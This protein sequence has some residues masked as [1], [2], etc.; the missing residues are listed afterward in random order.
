MFRVQSEIFTKV[1][2]RIAGGVLLVA[3]FAKFTGGGTA[4]GHSRRSFRRG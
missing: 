2:S 4:P 1:V 3:G